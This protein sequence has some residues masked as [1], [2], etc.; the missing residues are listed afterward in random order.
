MS[1]KRILVVLIVLLFPA[2]AL[3]EEGRWTFQVGTG[4][5]YSFP[6]WMKIQQDGQK[7]LELW[8]R[9]NTNAFS[10]Q[11][12]Y[13]NFKL[14]YWQDGKAWEF[15]SLH[16]K[17]YL[18]NKPDEVKTFNISHGYNMNMVNRAWEIG[19]FIYRLGGGFVMA[20]P[21]TEVRGHKKE[22]DGGINGFYISG[23]AVNGAIEKRWYVFRDLFLSLEAKLTA[24][25][26]VV[27]VYGGE[28][29]VPNVAIHGIGSIGY[30][31]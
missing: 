13:Y 12:I 17:V 18:K 19:P 8:G 2:L 24:A 21:E 11:A 9:Y 30:K 4:N 28:A 5:A 15:E 31:F 7:D 20:H 10:T 27:P 26:A 6:M 22:D 25:D 14:G 3:A 1:A 16:H 23:L 29:H